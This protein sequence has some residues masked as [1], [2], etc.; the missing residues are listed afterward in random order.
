MV[1]ENDELNSWDSFI[2]LSFFKANDLKSENDGYIVEDVTIVADD[3][4]EVNVRL[5]MSLN[6]MTYKFDLNKT[7]AIFLKEHE[8]KAPRLLLGKKIYFKK[9]LVFNPQTKKEVDGLRI[10]KIE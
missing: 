7:N 2:G 9:V 3:K 1:N 4:G 10:S 8:I 5:I 6:D